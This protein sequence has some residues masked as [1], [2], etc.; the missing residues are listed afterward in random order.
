MDGNLAALNR[1]LNEQDRLEKSL[2]CCDYCDER[3][4]EYYEIENMKICQ[5]CIDECKREAE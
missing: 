3:M 5:D 1:Y 4:A 2:P